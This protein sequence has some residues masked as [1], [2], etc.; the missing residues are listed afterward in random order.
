[1]P[2]PMIRNHAFVIL[3]SGLLLLFTPLL[4]GQQE[5]LLKGGKTI[6]GWVLDDNGTKIKVRLDTGGKGTAVT[7]IAY[8]ELAP[9]TIYRLMKR[10]TPRDD[11][12]G[13]L[14]LAEYCLEH[15]LYMVGRVH[16]R[17]ALT[18]DEK[19]GGRLRPRLEALRNR[20]AGVVLEASRK[21]IAEGKTLQAEKDLGLILKY[22]PDAPEAAEARRL[23]EEIAQKALEARLAKRKAMVKSH[24][25]RVRARLKTLRKDYE[26]AH[27]EIR[28]GL[29]VANKPVQAIKHY[30]AAVAAFDK[31]LQ[32]LKKASEEVQDDSEFSEDAR[33]WI[34][35]V[36]N[37]KIEAQLHMASAYFTRQTLTKA[38]EVVNAILADHPKHP[39]ALAMRGRIEVALNDDS[40][41]PRGRLRR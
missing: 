34:A 17:R 36:T 12:E 22:L 4:C 11:A 23:L 16:Y 10:R 39:E 5:I 28:R 20:A 13:Q 32:K 37:D 38:L 26:K 9:R 30:Q 7:T 2:L 24:A 40:G 6:R 21:L 18:L 35:I 8:D 15:G 31:I 19:Q 14:A 1:M 3:V 41:S 29:L 33:A 25:D 27:E